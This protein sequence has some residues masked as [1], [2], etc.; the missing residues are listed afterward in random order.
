MKNNLLKQYRCTIAVFLFWLFLLAIVYI[1][2]GNKATI[3]NIF[4]SLSFLVMLEIMLGYRLDMDRQDREAVRVKRERQKRKELG[5]EAW[6][7][8]KTRQ[9]QEANG[10]KR[11]YRNALLLDA[12]MGIV[13][14][15]L[16]R[17]IYGG[18]KEWIKQ[19][20]PELIWF[21]I[22]FLTLAI[23]IVSLPERKR[24]KKIPVW[25][26]L[27]ILPLFMFPFLMLL[28]KWNQRLIA[29][30]IMF[31]LGWV[32]SLMGTG[33]MVQVRNRKKN[34]TV[35]VTA[36]VVG[37][38]DSLVSSAIHR[39]GEIPVP[40]YHPVLEYY[41]DGEYKQTACD[42]GQPRPL[43]PGMVCEI[44]YNPERP[45][46]FQFA[47]DHTPLSEKLQGRFSLESE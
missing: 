23:W 30:Y 4:I 21:L 37:N 5:E 35:S 24:K 38:V 11:M 33:Y 1:G 25:E 22:T 29:V 32:F 27:F 36:K 14:M 34:C 46:E 2:Q 15:G 39:P 17:F 41:A 10:D 31:T 43:P 28:A 3:A 40:T 6:Q 26:P 9:E 45:E 19:A 13:Y 18:G 7:E 20:V 8:Y 44:Y 47:P 16:T 12:V 42:D